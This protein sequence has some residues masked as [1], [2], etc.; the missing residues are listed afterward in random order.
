MP[1]S[2]NCHHER[3]GERRVKGVMFVGQSSDK[4][5][6]VTVTARGKPSDNTLSGKQPCIHIQSRVFFL[7]SNV[8]NIPILWGKHDAKPQKQRRIPRQRHAIFFASKGWGWDMTKRRQLASGWSA[9]G[10]SCPSRAN[11]NLKELFNSIPFPAHA[12]LRQWSKF[13]PL[14]G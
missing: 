5:I 9:I 11:F 2:R 10:P 13:G 7:C 12:C 4:S 8:M 14:D 3:L 1:Q 6:E